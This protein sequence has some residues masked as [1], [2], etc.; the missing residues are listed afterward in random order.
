MHG[1]FFGEAR[2]RDPP[3]LTYLVCHGS[4]DA[5]KKNGAASGGDADWHELNTDPDHKDNVSKRSP[6]F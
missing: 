1:V 6:D 3:H 2:R 5:S 4:Q